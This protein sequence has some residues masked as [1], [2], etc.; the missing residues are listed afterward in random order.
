[1]GIQVLIS[2]QGKR[3]LVQ[4]VGKSWRVWL[5]LLVLLCA[6]CSAVPDTPPIPDPTFAAGL[7]LSLATVDPAAVLPEFAY[8]ASL[9]LDIEYGRRDQVEGISVIDFTFASPLGG[10][11]PARLVIPP[12]EGPFPAIVFMHG[13]GGDIGLMTPEALYFARLGAAGMLIE[14]PHI[15]P[16][17]YVPDGNQ[18]SGWPYFTEHDRRDQVQLIVDLQRAVDILAARPEVD[19]RRLAYI[20]ISYGG[21][22]GGLLAGVE[23]RLGAY[24]LV[25]G[26][27]GL[28]EHTSEPGPDGRPLHFSQPW[29][30][31]MWPIEPLH[32][33]GRAAPAALLFQNGTRDVL[34]PV[35]DA[36]RYQAAGS[37]PKTIMWYDGGHEIAGWS[38]VQADRAAWLQP[39]L[40]SPLAWF[41]PD[42]RPGTVLRDRLATLWAGLALAS[43]GYMLWALVRSKATAGEVFL[44]TLSALLLGPLA[45]FAYRA[46]RTHWPHAARGDAPQTWRV[47]LEGSV[48][49]PTALAGCMLAGMFVSMLV[50]SDSAAAQLAFQYLLPVLLF[51]L[52]AGRQRILSIRPAARLLLANAL[53]ALAAVIGGSISHAWGLTTNVDPRTW[54][55]FS[56]S[57][58]A[59]AL[60]L[61]P[62]TVVLR[63]AG[64]VVPTAGQGILPGDV[65]TSRHARRG[66]VAWSLLSFVPVVLALLVVTLT[67]SGTSLQELLQALH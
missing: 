66:A 8:D 40:A 49:L 37:E 30:D 46:S 5:W 43:A 17:G 56:C 12:G 41:E 45:P 15:R 11:V 27:G 61:L 51:V 32:F 54:L 7:E 44:W 26:D 13:S 24:V 3:T 29:V 31:L 64:W 47:L 48:L 10:R 50:R 18:G 34:V 20:G 67:A 42:Y 14:S 39:Y 2:Q 23:T 52:W 9:P 36:Q 62:L 1:M 28:V 16:G 59:G 55:I 63:S 21:A 25:V 19:A 6:A 53:W 33:V 35:T 38:S 4:V 65:T 22:M 58:L 60:A 57:A